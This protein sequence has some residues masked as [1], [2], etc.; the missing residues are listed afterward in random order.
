[1]LVILFLCVAKILE[2]LTLSSQR[3]RCSVTRGGV[4]DD[5]KSLMRHLKSLVLYSCR[6]KVV[7]FILFFLQDVACE[8]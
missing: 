8:P 3:L 7:F 4:K 1:M 6:D 5:D 2:P